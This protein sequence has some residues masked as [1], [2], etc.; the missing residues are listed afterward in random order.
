MSTQYTS[1]PSSAKPAAVTSPTYPVP[2]TPIG[3]RS[4]IGVASRSLVTRSTQ[5]RLKAPDVTLCASEFLAALGS[6][7]L[8]LSARVLEPF[9]ERGG[10]EV[11]RLYRLLDKHQRVVL[12]E[13]D[14][15]LRLREAQGLGLAVHQTQLGRFEQREHRLV[16]GE[17][18]DRSHGRLRR[19]HFHVV[20]EDLA[21]GRQ[22]LD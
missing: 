5:K 2:I 9:V 12:G 10:V 3:G 18:A 19:D 11:A 22:D 20:G 7:F 15:A 16:A 6:G 14:V 17:D 13:L 8:E 1:L 4:L 21:L